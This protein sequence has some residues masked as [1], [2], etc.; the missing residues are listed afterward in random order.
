M[1]ACVCVCMY[2]CIPMCNCRSLCLKFPRKHSVMMGFLSSMLREEVWDCHIWCCRLEP[3][4]GWN[5]T[6]RH[7][8][9]SCTGGRVW[10]RS[11][12]TSVGGCAGRVWVQA[13]DRGLDHFHHWG[14]L[15]S[16]GGRPGSPVWVYW[17]LWAHGAGNAYPAPARPRG[18][19][20]ATTIQV[21]PLHLQPSHPREPRRQSR[22]GM[23]SVSL[24]VCLSILNTVDWCWCLRCYVMIVH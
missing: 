10:L 16:E 19:A 4:C 21:R 24:S 13:S 17:G 6:V 2:V 15:G 20:H 9:V 7:T 22:S 18:S 11:E 14:E 12:G 8:H 3:L 23:P 5:C 1:R